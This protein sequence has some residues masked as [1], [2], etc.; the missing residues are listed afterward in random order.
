[1]ARKDRANANGEGSVWDRPDGRA[2]AALYVPTPDGAQQRVTTTKK[3]KREAR[4]WLRKML[5]DRDGGLV[6]NTDNPTVAEYF[7]SWLE[8]SVRVSVK[9][10]TY[11]HYK[12][13]S[14]NHVLPSLGHLR[15]KA[16]TAR[17]IQAL[18][19]KKLDAGYAIG[20]RRHVHTTIGKA[21]SQA[22]AWGD[23]PMNPAA[24]VS[25]PRGGAGA[26]LDRDDDVRPFTDDELRAIW[27][28]SPAEGRRRALWIFA[29]NSGL[30]PQELFALRWPDLH[31]PSS[32][33]GA[34]RVRW[35]LVRGEGGL[36]FEEVKTP[37]SRRTVEFLP[38]VVEVLREHHTRQLEE[39]VAAKRWKN[40][41][42][43]FPTTIGTPTNRHNLA[44][45]ELKPLLLRAGIEER[46]AFKDF[47]HTFA[48]LMFQRGRHPKEVQEMMGHASIRITMDLYSHWIP[49]MHG[50]AVDSLSDLFL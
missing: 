36:G 45:R 28:A 37:K 25:V 38:Q 2:G 16:V 1:M 27:E 29:P 50:S 33:K 6:I 4:K 18:H 24:H 43:V 15:M 7:A 17:H 5:A 23:I 41:D 12:R 8:D 10:V 46:H 19:A 48:T 47:R 13:I 22:A 40:L 32:G 21:F 11:E 14:K 20:T 42:L 26:A 3:S 9:P 35:A 39:Q 30:R 31:L 49:G 34:V 44:S